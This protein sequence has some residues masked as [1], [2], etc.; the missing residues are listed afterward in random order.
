MSVLVETEMGRD[1]K[2]ICMEVTGFCS[3]LSANIF[4]LKNVQKLNFFVIGVLLVIFT[5]C[6]PLKLLGFFAGTKI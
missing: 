2:D 5:H 6:L 3:Q 4:V 1:T